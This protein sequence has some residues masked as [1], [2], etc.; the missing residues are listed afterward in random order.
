MKR[1]DCFASIYAKF[2]HEQ[3]YWTKTPGVS[4]STLALRNMLLFILFTQVLMPTLQVLC[5]N[6]Y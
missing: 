1:R 3:D 4:N 5:K 2:D 6:P